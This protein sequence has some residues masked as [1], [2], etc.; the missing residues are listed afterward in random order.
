MLKNLRRVQ[1]PN[2]LQTSGPIIPVRLLNHV[3]NHAEIVAKAEESAAKIRERAEQDARHI[4]ETARERMAASIRRDLDA[5]KTLTQR[6]EQSLLTNSSKIC[7]EICKAVFDQMVEEMAPQQKI[8]IL[9]NNLLKANHHGRELLICCNPSQLDM[10][11]S[12]VARIMA[13]QLN[14]R[15][16]AVESRENITPF[17]VMISTSNG[18]EIRVSLDNLKVLYR[19]EIEALGQELE[20]LMHFNEDDNETFA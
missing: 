8:E 9:V 5:I 3:V 20:P 1:F 18:A 7:I 19:E 10:V 2:D 4:R 16:W 12:E 11:E 15:N 6:K 14:L 13:D 17:E